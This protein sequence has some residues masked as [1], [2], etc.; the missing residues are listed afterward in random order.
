MLRLVLD[1]LKTTQILNFQVPLVT[2]CYLK[3]NAKAYK[4]QID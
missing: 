2:S 1:L 3:K 4:T